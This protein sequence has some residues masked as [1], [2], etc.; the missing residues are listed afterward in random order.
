MGIPERAKRRKV[1]E[2][3]REA[4]GNFIDTANLYT[5]GASERLFERALHPFR[6][7]DKVL[8]NAGISA[9]FR[10]LYKTFYED[11]ASNIRKWL[12]THSGVSSNSKSASDQ[13]RQRE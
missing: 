13:S 5:N 12:D 6:T 4:G 2:T 9:T 3:T 1:Y 7:L 8:A 10:T 11:A